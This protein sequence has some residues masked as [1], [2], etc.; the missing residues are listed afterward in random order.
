MQSNLSSGRLLR[1]SHPLPSLLNDSQFDTFAFGKRHPRFR[2]FANGE[3]ITQSGCKLMTSSIL[4]MNGLKSA[5]VF[6]SVL[7]E[8][9]TAS[10]PSS[11]HHN[12]IPHIKFDEIGYLVLFQV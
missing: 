3:D 4:D 5:H 6:L 1:S 10:V 9:N 11:S 8:T 12:N 2:P 7:D